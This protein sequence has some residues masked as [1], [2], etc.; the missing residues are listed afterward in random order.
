MYI[1][2][3]HIFHTYIVHSL[4]LSVAKSKEKGKDKAGKEKGDKDKKDKDSK[5]STKDAKKD[6]ALLKKLSKPKYKSASDFMEKNFPNFDRD[7]IEEDKI[8]SC[9][10]MRVST[11]FCMYINMYT[12]I[13]MFTYRIR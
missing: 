13:H 8:N 7:E 2:Y 12:Y 9:G 10:P 4:H 6:A 5:K 3:I 1:P 11:V